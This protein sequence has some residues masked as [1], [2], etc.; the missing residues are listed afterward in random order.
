MDAKR[1]ALRAA[2]KAGFIGLVGVSITRMLRRLARP[3]GATVV[4][5]RG[6]AQDAASAGVPEKAE[7]RAEESIGLRTKVDEPPVERVSPPARFLDS[8]TI[9]HDDGFEETGAAVDLTE[10]PRRA[11]SSPD[12]PTTNT[13]TA[14]SGMPGPSPINWSFTVDRSQYSKHMGVNGGV[15]RRNSERRHDMRGDKFC[16]KC[17]LE[18]PKSGRCDGCD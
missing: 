11:V 14:S 5:L 15:Y 1:R 3:R 4:D 6:S 13:P 8:Q 10:A 18:L 12:E 16:P 9:E 2:T 7:P 17:N